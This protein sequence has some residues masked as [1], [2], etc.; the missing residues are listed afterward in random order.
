M[1]PE[2]SDSPEVILPDSENGSGYIQ[3][4]QL[5]SVPQP[6]D[7]TSH[8]EQVFTGGRSSL[9]RKKL[10]VIIA[11]ITAALFAGGGATLVMQ[12]SDTAETPDTIASFDSTEKEDIKQETPVLEERSTGTTDD[13]ANE[14]KQVS[15][16]PTIPPEITTQLPK[17]P[18]TAPVV[19]GTAES[20][21]RDFIQAIKDKNK[22]KSDSLQSKSFTFLLNDYAGDGSYYSYCDLDELCKLYSWFE[23]SKAVVTSE[24][25]RSSAGTMGSTTIFTVTTKIDGSTS[26]NSLRVSTIKESAS[27]KVD[28][29]SQSFSGT[30]S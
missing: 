20:I 25:Y 30:S 23:I 15:D 18:V 4:V 19:A 24:E 14:D 10:A 3:P 17:T 6:Y 8:N 5:A 26:K 21:S 2:N 11:I 29:I 9:P 13:K 16:T 28:D 27:Y 7:H 1:N 22:S 12:R